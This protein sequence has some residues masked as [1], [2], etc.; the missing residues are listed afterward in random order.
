VLRSRN[1]GQR[2]E[3]EGD[4]ALCGEGVLSHPARSYL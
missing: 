4:R 3:E 1:G 2:R